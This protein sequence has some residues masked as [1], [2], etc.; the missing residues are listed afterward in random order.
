MKWT[1][2]LII[3]KNNTNN[4]NIEK[5]EVILYYIKSKENIEDILTS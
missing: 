1:K 4:E 2:I 3:F 5:K